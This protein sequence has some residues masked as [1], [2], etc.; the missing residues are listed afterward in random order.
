MSI[1]K[2]TLSV[3][4]LPVN[5]YSKSGNPQARLVV[6]FFLLHGR[7]SSAE[8]I[9]AIAR[10]VVERTFVQGSKRRDRDLLIVTFVSGLS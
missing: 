5:V 9:D 6:V 7:H 1:S 4:G 10:L 2:Q 3:A 8:E